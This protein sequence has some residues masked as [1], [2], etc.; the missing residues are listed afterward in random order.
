MSKKK[1]V[2]GS[3]SRR[4]RGDDEQTGADFDRIQEKT[5][6]NSVVRCTFKIADIAS[7]NLGSGP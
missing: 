6:Y 2:G 4:L 1:V 5:R 7:G 3:G